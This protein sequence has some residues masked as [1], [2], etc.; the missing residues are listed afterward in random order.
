MAPEHRGKPGIAIRRGRHDRRAIECIERED[1]AV[2]RAR[3][4]GT[5]PVSIGGQQAAIGPPLSIPS[6]WH[7]VGQ[8]P[9]RSYDP[10]RTARPFLFAPGDAIRFEPIGASDYDA[11]CAAAE[12]GD[13]VARPEPSVAEE[14]PR[15]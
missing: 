1:V 6:G 8:T 11:L 15:D 9:V 7:L 12:A 3:A 2:G 4:A 14:E 10:A 5:G 13:L